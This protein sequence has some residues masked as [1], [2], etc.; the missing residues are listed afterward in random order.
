MPVGRRG[1]RRITCL[2]LVLWGGRGE[3]GKLY[4]VIPISKDWADNVQGQAV[5]SGHYLAEEAPD[6]TYNALSAFFG[7]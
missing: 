2:L 5:D 3:V 7:T 4:D 6:E 1:K